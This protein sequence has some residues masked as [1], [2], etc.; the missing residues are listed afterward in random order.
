MYLKTLTQENHFPGTPRSCDF[1]CD[2]FRGLL[3]TLQNC[4]P[5]ALF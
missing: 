2:N 3:T 1:A 4:R 5:L